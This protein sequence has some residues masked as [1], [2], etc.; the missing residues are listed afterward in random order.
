M[1]KEIDAE[2]RIYKLF[3]TELKK[4]SYSHNFFLTD[5]FEKQLLIKSRMV[6][7]EYIKDKWLD[8]LSKNKSDKVN[9][10]IGV[11][12]CYS[13]CEFCI[14]HKGIAKNKK[15]VRD[16][17]KC[18]INQIN[19]YSDVLC[20]RKFHNL[21]FGGG[22]PSLFEEE[23]LSD[24]LKAFFKYTEF[25]K[26]SEKTFEL[27]PQ[28]TTFD[29]LKILKNSGF[30]RVSFGVQSFGKKV[31][32]SINRAYQNEKIIT[33]CI[34]YS[35]QLGFEQ[36]NTDMIIG[37]YSDNKET[38]I[39]SMKK[40]FDLKPTTVRL[41][42]CQ[43][44]SSYLNKYFKGDIKLYRKHFNDLRKCIPE[45]IKYAKE[46][47]YQ[48]G[49]DGVLDS[50]N[51]AAMSF[52]LTTSQQIEDVY[53]FNA[54]GIGSILGL[55]H[56]ASSY[57]LNKIRYFST[58]AKLDPRKSEFRI[59]EFS[60]KGEMQRFLFDR[61]S[62]TCKISKSVFKNKFKKNV[63]Y[64]FTEALKN[65]DQLQKIKK[66]SD[67]I[68]FL[69]K[70][71][72][73]KFL[74]GLFFIGKEKVKTAIN[75]IYSDNLIKLNIGNKQFLYRIEYKF[76]AEDIEPTVVFLSKQKMPEPYQS[77]VASVFGS[78]DNKGLDPSEYRGKLCAKLIPSLSRLKLE[79]P[80]LVLALSVKPLDT[81]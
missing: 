43:P 58:P 24:I 74:Y 40:I 6:N 51:A 65:L 9:I 44:T 68:L 55:G 48:V 61:I 73:E 66:D 62:N 57:I 5:L 79:N 20:K 41:Y 64:V 63:E 15:Q 46:R 12:Y 39:S 3:M 81:V 71:S 38:F 67:N 22:T 11:P 7:G 21:Y 72:K 70:S 35:R 28:S 78:V 69:P 42:K 13:K 32:N 29:K 45:I 36:I 33:D 17:A 49:G 76:G 4:H 16:Y 2:I 1:K 50:G 27:N 47:K 8:Y 26:S 14:Y 10:Y 37:L 77:E 52:K 54:D 53:H 75:Q 30:N 23:D 59:T 34:N 80:S 60:K 31:L 19:Y 18:L 25:K 56:H